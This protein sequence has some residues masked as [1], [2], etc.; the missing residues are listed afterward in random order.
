MGLRRTLAILGGLLLGGLLVA[1]VL[2]LRPDDT[3]IDYQVVRGDTLSR[4]AQRHGV[5]VAELQSWNRLEGDLIEVGQVLRI[6]AGGATP[7]PAAPPRRGRK[8]GPASSGGARAMPPEKPCLPP[9]DPDA[10]GEAGDE[11]AYLASQG[12]SHAQVEAA[13]EAFL[14]GLYACVPEGARPD[15][16]LAIELLVACGGRVAEVRVVDDDGLPPALVDC[17]RSELRYAAF[18]AH[19][20]PDGFGFAYPISFRW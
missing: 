4:I 7:E 13:M 3:G 8:T 1:G 18:P 19:D 14:P 5:T 11:P 17:V 16:V 15:G 2:L 20:L 12:L 10:L 9:P 6:H